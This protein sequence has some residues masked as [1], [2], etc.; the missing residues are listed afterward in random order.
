MQAGA[1]ESIAHA[2][3]VMMVNDLAADIFSIEL[4]AWFPLYTL[5]NIARKFQYIPKSDQGWFIE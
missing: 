4:T 1:F 3:V 2:E 5:T